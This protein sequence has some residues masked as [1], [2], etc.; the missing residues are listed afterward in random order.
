MYLNTHISQESQSHLRL[1]RLKGLYHCSP[2]FTSRPLRTD[3][4]RQMISYGGYLEITC[5]ISVATVSVPGASVHWWHGPTHAC[6]SCSTVHFNDIIP[7]RVQSGSRIP[8]QK[9]LYIHVVLL[10]TRV[11][12]LLHCCFV[13]RLGTSWIAKRERPVLWTWTPV[14]T[15]DS[16]VL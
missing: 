14:I 4:T 9:A 5:L 3:C 1:H 13:S 8:K 11:L 6:G 16:G 10:L 15:F 12:L 2:H 7:L